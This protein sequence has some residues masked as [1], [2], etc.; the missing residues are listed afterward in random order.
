ME[1]TVESANHFQQMSLNID[2]EMFS[3]WQIVHKDGYVGLVA[4]E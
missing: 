4:C 1:S 3:N 2:G